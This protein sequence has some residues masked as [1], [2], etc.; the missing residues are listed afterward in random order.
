M[1]IEA[2]LAEK[3]V[4]ERLNLMPLTPRAAISCHLARPCRV[5]CNITHSGLACQWAYTAVD[6]VNPSF[7]HSTTTFS[8]W[9]FVQPKCCRDA[10]VRS[11]G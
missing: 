11:E 8:R 5:R 3:D 10:H 4:T 7:A 2:S 6:P 9:L 1:A